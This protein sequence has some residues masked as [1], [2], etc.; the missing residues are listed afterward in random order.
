MSGYPNVVHGGIVASLMDEAMGVIFELN[1][2]LRKDLPAFK[3]DNVTA[4][5]DVTYLKPVNTNSVL[6]I[7]S[8]VEEMSGRKTRITC[9]VAN[10]KE[11]V[12]AKCS[13]RWMS[14]KPK[15]KL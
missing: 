8:T 9:E 14:L 6:C 15:A 13:S 7:T 2:T 5:L 1:A 10:E 12:L 3:A 11:D 4:G